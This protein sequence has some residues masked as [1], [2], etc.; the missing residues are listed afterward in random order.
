MSLEHRPA[1]AFE[2]GA[3]VALYVELLDEVHWGMS[4]LMKGFVSLTLI[5]ALELVWCNPMSL[6]VARSACPLHPPQRQ[7]QR[8]NKEMTANSEPEAS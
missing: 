7:N 3:A 6:S 4:M 1:R 2:H 8:Q 5:W